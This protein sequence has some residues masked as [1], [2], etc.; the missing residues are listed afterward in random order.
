MGCVVHDVESSRSLLWLLPHPEYCL[1][2]DLELTN[3]YTH[4]TKLLILWR[5]SIQV[6][7]MFSA[8]CPRLLASWDFW[9][10]ASIASLWLLQLNVNLHLLNRNLIFKL[11]SFAKGRQV[12]SYSWLGIWEDINFSIIIPLRPFLLSVFNKS[13]NNTFSLLPF[14]LE[15]VT[16][17]PLRLWI[18]ND[19]GGIG[20]WS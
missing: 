15:N 6:T 1:S 5:I 19:G 12:I 9:H 14:P 10:L 18:S 2:T 3:I 4:I 13:L 16:P 20:T 11:S 8:N 7:L 17:P